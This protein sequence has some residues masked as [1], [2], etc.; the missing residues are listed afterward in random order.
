MRPSWTLYGWSLALAMLALGL[1]AWSSTL[2]S[3]WL[4][5]AG[6]AAVATAVAGVAVSVASRRLGEPRLVPDFSLAPP[7]AAGGL[8]LV[9]VAVA[10]GRWLVLV[11]LGVLALAGGMLVREL[12]AQRGAGRR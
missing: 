1:L 10:A 12:V 2:R 7:V 5:L 9:L 3:T 4:V 6:A 11:G 8:L